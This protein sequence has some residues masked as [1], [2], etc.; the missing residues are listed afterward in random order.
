MGTVSRGFRGRRPSAELPP[1]HSTWSRTSPSC[2]PDQPPASTCRTGSTSSPAR[3][4][5]SGAG[6]GLASATPLPL[7]ARPSRSAAARRPGGP[8]RGRRQGLPGRV[9]QRL[10][11]SPQGL[12]PGQER[13]RRARP[14]RGPPTRRRGGQQL[15]D[16]T[17]SRTSRPCSCR[18]PSWRRSPPR[19]A[20]GKA[21]GGL[22]GCDWPVALAT[23]GC[24]A[25]PARTRLG[26]PRAPC[27]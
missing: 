15:L 12:H 1:G 7:P 26:G 13:R 5:S 10:R 21:G 6:T 14:I 22:S 27:E 25:S 24:E 2:Q 8:D 23:G 11:R 20:A 18:S 16:Q 3:P 4:T 9:V 19:R 17:A